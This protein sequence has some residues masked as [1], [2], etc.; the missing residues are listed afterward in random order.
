MKNSVLAAIASSRR[1]RSVSVAHQAASAKSS[2][3]LLTKRIFDVS[4]SVIFLIL[5]MPLIV[6][7]AILL[8]TLQGRPILIRHKRIGKDGNLFDCLKLRTMTVNADAAL[9]A[10]LAVSATARKEWEETRK[11]KDDP[12]IT[13]AGRVLRKLSLDELP[14]MINVVKG[15]MSLVGPRPI[16]LDEVRFYGSHIQAY[17]SVRPGLTGAWQVGGRNDVSYSKRVQM[18]VDYATGWSLGR[19]FVILIKTFPALLNM[20]GSY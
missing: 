6:T 10:H 14:Q 3:G 5:F 9:Q 15:E 13:P 2:T 7:F 8:L 18:D 1:E 16:V 20:R 11:L 12:R 4:F 19:D 17:Q